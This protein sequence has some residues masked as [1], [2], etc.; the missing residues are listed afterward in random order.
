MKSLSETS[1]DLSTVTTRL[2]KEK[3]RVPR[4]RSSASSCRGGSR[5]RTRSKE[6][7][8]VEILD[9]I[10]SLEIISG[11]ISTKTSR[12]PSG[13]NLPVFAVASYSQTITDSKNGDIV[14]CN[15]PSTPLAKS[16]SSCIGNRDRYDAAFRYPN[17]STSNNALEAIHLTLP[18][19]VD[20]LSM[21]GYEAR[22]I[23]IT[24]SIMRGCE[25]LELGI[26]SL[27]LE[28]HQTHVSALVPIVDDRN[29]KITRVNGR[30]SVAST[31]KNTGAIGARSSAF[32]EDPSQRYSLQ[33]ATMRVSI[34]CKKRNTDSTRRTTSKYLPENPPPFTDLLGQSSSTISGIT[35]PGSEKLTKDDVYSSLSHISSKS[36]KITKD[37]YASISNCGGFVTK[38]GNSPLNQISLNLSGSESEGAN[39]IDEYSALG[40]DHKSEKRFASFPFESEGFLSGSAA[41]ITF[42]HGD[43]MTLE[44]SD[45]GSKKYLGFYPFDD[46]S[47]VTSGSIGTSFY[48]NIYDKEDTSSNE[49]STIL[50]DVSL[51]TIRLKLGLD[52]DRENTES[53]KSIAKDQSRSEKKKRHRLLRAQN[54]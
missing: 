39:T 33:R 30:K 18:M 13:K 7:K 15:I 50:D 3:T 51:G 36:A 19:V 35:G 32:R 23:D 53:S 12:R 24:I 14:K 43:A 17:Y 2:T 45:D 31:S 11:I 38:H 26:A 10:V 6:S 49:R 20:H 4:S 9:F 34:E 42:S 41:S 5:S 21:S 25:V 29:R 44:N 46:E 22:Q 37:V 28:G 52:E 27:P 40:S 16:P 54:Q 48:S 47:S 1:K 8:Q